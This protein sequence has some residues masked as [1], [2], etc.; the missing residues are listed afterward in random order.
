MAAPSPRRGSE[1]GHEFRADGAANVTRAVSVH[2][3]RP[4]RSIFV[5][6][7][8]ADGWIATDLTVAL[9]R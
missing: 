3:T 1:T 8:N 2:N 4:E 5:E 9:E 7:G 6:E